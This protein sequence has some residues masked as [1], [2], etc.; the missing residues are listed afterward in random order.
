MLPQALALVPRQNFLYESK[1][2]QT[3]HDGSAMKAIFKDSNLSTYFFK[4]LY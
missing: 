1:M 2:F 4:I 3:D